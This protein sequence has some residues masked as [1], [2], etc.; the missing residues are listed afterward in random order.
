MPNKTNKR[1]SLDTPPSYLA[2]SPFIAETKMMLARL[3]MWVALLHAYAAHTT[4]STH[5]HQAHGRTF[6]L[7]YLTGSDRLPE[8]QEYKRPGLLISG[9]ITLAVE[10]VSGTGNESVLSRNCDNL[11]MHEA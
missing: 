11:E 6:T 7:G 9:A 3:A 10:E 2:F 4:H 5:N 1:P 8:D